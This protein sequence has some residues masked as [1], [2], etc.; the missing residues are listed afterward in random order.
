MVV[1]GISPRLP[2]S[3]PRGSIQTAQR[4]SPMPDA[5]SDSSVEHCLDTTHPESL[6]FCS[7]IAFSQEIRFPQSPAAANEVILN[8]KASV[9]F[10]GAWSGSGDAVAF[11]FDPCL[12]HDNSEGYKFLYGSGHMPNNQPGMN[13]VNGQTSFDMVTLDTASLDATNFDMICSDLLHGG[14]LDGS[15]N[16][17]VKF[18]INTSLFDIAKVEASN[19]GETE[20]DII[21]SNSANPRA[22]AG[23]TDT[24]MMNTDENDPESKN[25][26][27][28]NHETSILSATSSTHSPNFCRGMAPSVPN[29][30]KSHIGNF[31]SNTVMTGTDV[32]TAI[33]KIPAPEECGR[34]WDSGVTNSGMNNP[35][36]CR[37]TAWSPA[38]EKNS[39]T[40]DMNTK[41]TGVDGRTLANDN[42]IRYID[43]SHGH[44][45]GQVS[46]KDASINGTGVTL[47]GSNRYLPSSEVLSTSPWK[48]NKGVYGYTKMSEAHTAKTGTMS[49]PST[50][51]TPSYD[52]Q[53]PNPATNRKPEDLYSQ[54]TDIR[55]NNTAMS[56][57][58]RSGHPQL[59]PSTTT[60]ASINNPSFDQSIPR[61]D[62][63][64]NK[65]PFY[66]PIL[67]KE[68]RPN[69]TTMSHSGCSEQ[70][71]TPDTKTINPSTNHT[72]P[73][74]TMGPII[75]IYNVVIGI[76][77]SASPCIRA[78]GCFGSIAIYTTP[79]GMT[80]V[81]LNGHK[82]CNPTWS[83]DAIIYDFCGDVE[84]SKFSVAFYPCGGPPW[85]IECAIPGFC[86]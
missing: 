57:E 47:S 72:T 70:T 20:S 13:H 32:V 50:E 77:H 36:F 10:H 45:C 67:P 49:A 73:G 48:R 62:T 38:S 4:D 34:V 1:E 43:V 18:N 41:D 63:T 81:S 61:N 39:D 14:L 9:D 27:L 58:G 28:N 42:G 64:T 54:K 44:S 59:S 84:I 21:N 35:G 75:P 52:I 3:S 85:R 16:G 66:R 12:P 69:S 6:S 23:L 46:T 60:N 5:T 8:D 26:K 76:D 65:T 11:D 53:I 71:P 68:T 79:T 30:I 56:E 82:T 25:V 22:N 86:E 78:S 15:T 7:A 55:G 40:S 29:V 80:Q 83:A 2:I 31:E 24:A 37:S 33:T 17:N 19:N 74:T 51:Q